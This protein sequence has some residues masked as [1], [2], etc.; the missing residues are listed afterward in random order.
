MSEF[1]ENRNLV[2]PDEVI[3]PIRKNPKGKVSYTFFLLIGYDK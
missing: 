3:S 1:S 2:E